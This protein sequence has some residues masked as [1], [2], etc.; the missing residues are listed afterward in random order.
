MTDNIK[1]TSG[2]SR[3]GYKINVVG[4]FGFLVIFL[5]AMVAIFAPYLIPHPVGEIVDLDY[6]GPMTSDLW[7]GSDYLGRDVFSRILMGARFTVGISLAAVTIACVSGVVLG[8]SA[9][10]VGGWFDAALSRFLDAVNSI[11]SKLFGLVVVAA[12]GSSIPVLIVTLSVIYTP[13]AYRFARALAVNVNTMDFVT[14]ARVRGESLLHL[15]SSEILPNI[16]RPVLADLGVRFVFIVLLLS[17]LS[18]LGLGL[19]PPNADWGAL[20]RENIGGLPF[21][22]PAVI[23]P[24]L[25]IASLTISVNLLID[26]LPQK[27]RD[28][29]E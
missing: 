28:R 2:T 8:M 17:G 15:I 5:W 1:T 13:G 26:N 6:F 9:A 12:V 18:F 22:A 24:S 19:Q 7:L 16:I 3:L 23:F 10:V 20:V 27:I 25:A 11:P 14:V 4:V 29:S 21:A